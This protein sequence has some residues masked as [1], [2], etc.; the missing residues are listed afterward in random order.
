MEVGLGTFDRYNGGLEDTRREACDDPDCEGG[1]VDCR[2][3]G[4]DGRRGCAFCAD[5]GV[6]ALLTP[7]RGRCPECDAW[8]PVFGEMERQARAAMVAAMVA[9]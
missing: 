5:E 4:G 9:L 1:M 6:P 3:C 8:D 7:G 2:E